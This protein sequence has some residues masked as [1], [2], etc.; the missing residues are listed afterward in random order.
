[1]KD[2]CQ[3]VTAS[4]ATF[5]PIRL[6]YTGAMQDFNAP[7]YGS[8]KITMV[9]GNGGGVRSFDGSYQGASGAKLFT[10]YNLM[11]GETTRVLVA[12]RGSDLYEPVGGGGGGGTFVYGTDWFLIGVAGGGGGTGL[13]DGTPGS[14][15]RQA[16]E[17]GVGAD[18]V[19]D[20]RG[21]AG[22]VN[23]GGGGQG[24]MS[25]G[26]VG[27][28]GGGSG[29]NSAGTNGIPTDRGGEG[30]RTPGQGARGGNGVSDPNAPV[31]AGRGGFGGGGGAGKNGHFT[32][33]GGGGG[34]GGGWAGG[35]GGGQIRA[36]A[37]GGGGGGSS[38]TWDGII[39]AM[40]QDFN[41]VKDGYVEFL[42]SL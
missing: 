4:S 26:N 37:A 32:I 10:N 11:R 28:G 18:Y 29:W 1:M 23:N 14:T 5:L 24:G 12:G 30:G 31:G 25:S 2:V 3:D 22:D 41:Q 21:Q 16:R 6:S 42:F 34:G 39:G 38:Y 7:Y 8:Y 27:A 33:L 9:G 13:D 17:G 36:N 15:T 20:R 40:D 35:G 19:A